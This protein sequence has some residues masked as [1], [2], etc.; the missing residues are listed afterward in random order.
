MKIKLIVCV[1]LAAALAAGCASEKRGEWRH[2]QKGEKGEWQSK[3]KV[4]KAD[5]EQTALAKV[6]DGTIK[7]AELE[8]E[9]GKLF[10]S[11]DMATPGTRDITEVHVD[12]RTGAVVSVSKEWPEQENRE[13][14]EERDTD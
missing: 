10:W 5:A 4:S 8:K 3:A 13:A 6:P 14:A 1:A 11:F 12:A 2:H 7:E 9:H